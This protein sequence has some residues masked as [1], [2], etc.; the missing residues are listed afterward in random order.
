VEAALAPFEPRPHWGKMFT[1]RPEQFRP[2]FPRL[3][4]FRTLLQK[5]DPRGKF[6]NAFVE[7]NIF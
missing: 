6:R 7:R 3:A 4:D 5:H 1:M 2:R